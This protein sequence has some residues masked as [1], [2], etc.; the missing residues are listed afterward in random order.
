MRKSES[1]GASGEHAVSA[2]ASGASEN[3]KASEA[4]K[5]E[6]RVARANKRTSEQTSD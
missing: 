3:E 2:R 4:R 5:Q 1:K 6:A